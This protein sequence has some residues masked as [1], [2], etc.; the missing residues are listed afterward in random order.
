MTYAGSA[1]W[2]CL[3]TGLEHK[4]RIVSAIEDLTAGGS[5]AMGSGLE[6]AYQEAMKGLGPDAEPRAGAVRRRRQ[7]RRDLAPRAPRPHRRQGQGGVTL[8][9]IGF[10]MGS[11]R[12][13]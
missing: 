4:G 13:R 9:T 8:S 11:Y 3:A 10:G 5:T 12:T 7:R 6:L 2:C 1:G